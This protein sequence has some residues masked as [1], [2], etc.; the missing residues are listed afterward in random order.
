MEKR[1][2]QAPGVSA[3]L[4]AAACIFQFFFLERGVSLDGEG[5]IFAIGE[6]LSRGETLY[7]DR[8]TTAAPLVYEL[9]AALF[10]IF[11]PHILVGRVVVVFA[12]ASAT[13]LVHRIL[14]RFASPAAAAAGA[15][16]LWPIKPLGFPLWN[17][18]DAAQIALLF[19]LAAVW[20]SIRWFHERTRTWLALAGLLVGLTLVAKWECGVHITLAATV[21]TSFDWIIHRPRHAPELIRTLAI[22]FAASAVP[23]AAMAMFYAAHGAGGEFIWRA[24]LSPFAAPGVYPVSLPGLCAWSQHADDLVEVFA[25]FPAILID[26]A[27]MGRVDFHDPSQLVSWEMAIKA[28]YYV[29][30][31]AMVGVCLMAIARRAACSQARRSAAVMV[32]VCAVIAYLATARADWIHLMRNY[33]V[34]VLPLLVAVASWSDGDVRWRRALA[35][36]AWLGWMAFGVAATYAIGT[37]Y[38]DP[39]HSLRGRILDAPHRA[40]ELIRVLDYLAE[41]S[42]ES[43]V[44]FA[45]HIPLYYFLTG[46]SI[47]VPNDLILPGMVGGD[48]DDRRLA[49]DTAAVD[50]VVYDPRVSHA[51]PARLYSFAPRTAAVL[52]SRFAAEAEISNAAIALRKLGTPSPQVVVDLWSAPESGAT[53]PLREAPAWAG[54]RATSAPAVMRDHWMVYRVVSLRLAERGGEQCF[55]RRHCVA[56]GEALAALPITHPVGWGPSSGVSV[57]FAIRARAG[58]EVATLFS[59]GRISGD[60]P[61]EIRVPLAAH[62]GHCVDLEFCATALEDG[63]ALG[64]AGWAEPRIVRDE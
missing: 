37:V 60:A 15:L 27:R 40:G 38:T 14:L 41:E 25:Y 49:D 11:E 33:V 29:P 35:C 5:S 13:V 58:S 55:A 57:Q 54:D 28:A 30:F 21:A 62:A 36:L 6:S 8:V 42:P 26:L 32:A 43:R 50:L 18:L 12:F 52:A 34:I 31:V 7:R 48:E 10:R 39:V 56:A 2:A 24:A 59:D 22:L 61:G 46:R 16:A 19:Q 44:L 23:V 20:A 53:E 9:V 47:P 63:L 64:V 3:A 51:V 1:G 45:P 4:F 17:V